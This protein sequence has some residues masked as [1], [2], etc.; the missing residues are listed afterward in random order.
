MIPINKKN[1]PV[2][3]YAMIDFNAEGLACIET[4]ENEVILARVDDRGDR[5]DCYLEH[6]VDD[7]TDSTVNI[8]SISWIEWI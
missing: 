4:K 6:I 8:R 1:C 2:K 3:K 7:K 5:D